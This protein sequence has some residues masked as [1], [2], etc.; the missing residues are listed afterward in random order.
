MSFVTSFSGTCVYKLLMS[1]LA[2]V[3]VYLI[4]TLDILLTNS[5][6]DELNVSC[7]QHFICFSNHLARLYSGL[8]TADYTGLIR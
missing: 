2:E 5:V 4:S 6:D 1:K 8:L 7:K 3:F